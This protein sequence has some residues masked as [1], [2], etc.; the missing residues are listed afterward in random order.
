M[1]KLFDEKPVLFAVIWIV[2]YVVGVGTL[3]SVSEN[4]TVNYAA[5]LGACAAI[6][7]VLLIFAKKH[8]L[9]EYWY[10]QRYRGDWK[11]A[12]FFLP[13]AVAMTFNLWTGIAL[14]EIPAGTVLLGVAAKGILAPFLE[15][16]ILRAMLYRA[17]A[18]ESTRRAFWITTVTF[19][20]GHIVNLVF[21]RGSLET[22]VQVGYA[23][24]IGFLFTVIMA[25]GR[26]ILPT[27]I[28]HIAFNSLSFFGREPSQAW[29]GYVCI[30]VL[31]AVCVGYGV[32]LLRASGGIPE[33]TD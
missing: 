5:M 1:K 9:T 23:L 21:G 30:G 22:L 3:G 26:S 4:D 10:M 14:P 19:G 17:I 6:A 28:A 33:K 12:L 20:A 32:Y 24:C 2:I 18:K 8:G 16:L 13:L 25:A 15:E 11:Q 31:C 29:V 27:V 7:A